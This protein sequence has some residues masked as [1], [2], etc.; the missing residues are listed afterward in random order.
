MEQ[1]LELTIN[2][3]QL[4][5]NEKKKR[6]DLETENQYLLAKN[7]ILISNQNAG[8]K[9]EVLLLIKLYNLN[10]TKQYDKLIDIFGE[11]ASEGISILNMNTKDEILDINKLSKAKGEFKAD[12][13]IQMKKTGKQIC[14]SI[15][16]K[17]GGAPSVMNSQRRDQK[18]FQSGGDLNY[19]LSD[20]DRIVRKY[21]DLRNEGLPEEIKFEKLHNFMTEDKKVL[22]ELIWYFMFK[23]SGNNTSKQMADSLLIIEGIDIKYISL[24]NKEDQMK[25]IND[26]WNLFNIS[27][28][29]HKNLGKIKFKDQI[30]TKCMDDIKYKQKYDIMKPWIYETTD[31]GKNNPDNKIKVKTALHI[32]MN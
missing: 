13:M 22:S 11:E 3:K 17:N 19:L 4:Y 18:V 24:I 5:I 30:E 16:Y 31:N 7:K 27:L 12:C 25:Y 21:H 29:S 2:Y 26:N 10:Q 1:P 6:Q 9:Y 8:E 32:R 23:G 28:I 14:P 20:I 15:K